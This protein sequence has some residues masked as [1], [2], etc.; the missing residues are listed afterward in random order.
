[1][2]EKKNEIKSKWT[3]WIEIKLFEIIFLPVSQA[4]WEAASTQR[5]K[6]PNSATGEK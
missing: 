1:M 4:F 5:R 6:V 2:G 3:N